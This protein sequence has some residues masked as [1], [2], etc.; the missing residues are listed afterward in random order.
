[1][2]HSYTEDGPGGLTQVVLGTG[3][4]MAIG[5]FTNFPNTFIEMIGTKN[6]PK[7][8]STMANKSATCASSTV[9]TIV[10]TIGCG[11]T[12]RAAHMSQIT[13]KSAVKK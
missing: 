6:P 11:G 13:L 12:K 2:T 4:I 8:I 9:D 5:L 1:M 7:L 10:G 3:I